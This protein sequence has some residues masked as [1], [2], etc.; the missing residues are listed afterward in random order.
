MSVHWAIGTVEAGG[1]PL[2]VIEVG[3]RL[4]EIGRAA[5]ALLGR[6]SSEVS[7]LG[8]LEKW[9]PSSGRLVEL[10]DAI[11]NGDGEEFAVAAH[12]GWFA[13]ILHPRKVIGVGANYKDHLDF[14]GIPYPKTPYLFLK[15]ASTTLF[16]HDRTL[17]IPRQVGYPDWEGELGVVIGRRGRNIPVAEALSFVAGYTPANDFSARDWLADAI[18]PLGS[19]WLLH[20]GW[21]GFTPIGPL[22]TPASAIDDPQQLTIKLTVDGEIKQDGST[23]NMVFGVAELIAHASTMLT[24]EPGDVLLTGT[25]LGSGMAVVPPQRLT[26]GQTMVLEIEGLGTLRTPTVAEGEQR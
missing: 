23:A 22:I 5:Q 4:Y 7:V 13:P 19:D 25:P 21:D 12:D 10:A 8:L 9:E 16:G 24:L 18:P 6:A 14:A 1:E 15:P 2:A 3:G 11:A 26:P 17:T 20:K